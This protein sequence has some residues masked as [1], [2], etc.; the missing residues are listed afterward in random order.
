MGVVMGMGACA[1]GR[2]LYPGVPTT[3]STWGRVVESYPGEKLEESILSDHYYLNVYY[4][5][6]VM[7]PRGKPLKSTRC[8]GQN[9]SRRGLRPERQHITREEGFKSAP[10]VIT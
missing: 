9:G 7:Y 2:N 6:R 8:D 4:R 1:G 3:L 10:R 5:S